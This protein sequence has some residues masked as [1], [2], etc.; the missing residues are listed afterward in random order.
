M[1]SGKS[2]A[3]AV[4]QKLEANEVAVGGEC[5]VDGVVL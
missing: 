5:S 1:K 3:A 2:C 4:V